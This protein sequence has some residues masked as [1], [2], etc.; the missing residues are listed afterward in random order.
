M[1]APPPVG[2]RPMV[3]CCVAALVFLEASCGTRQQGEDEG[4]DWKRDSTAYETAMVTWRH[5]SLVIDSV[6]RTIKT[7]TLFGLYR[8]MISA[9]TPYPWLQRIS[10][11]R[12]RLTWKYGA[13]PT[14]RA[15]QRMRDSLWNGVADSIR[16]RYES[17][18]GHPVS[19]VIGPETCGSFGPKGP[20]VVNGVHMSAAG[21][22]PTRPKVDARKR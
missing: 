19:V 12:A 14:E 21:P 15:V 2:R 9:P 16:A 17:T 3:S 13:L 18:E 5:D 8:R 6:S 7:D 11:A 22:R 4:A 10:C 20:S 1:N